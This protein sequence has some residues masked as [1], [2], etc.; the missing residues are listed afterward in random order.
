MM[1][2]SSTELTSQFL[3]NPLTQLVVV[4][5]ILTLVVLREQNIPEPT[6]DPAHGTLTHL[7]MNT[8]MLLLEAKAAIKIV[9]VVVTNAVSVSTQVMQTFSKRLVVTILDTGLQTKSV[10]CSKTM[11]LHSIVLINFPLQWTDSITGITTLVQDLV[12]A[13]KTEQELT[14]VGVP[15]GMS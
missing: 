14:A 9:T 1:L 2:R 10:V 3:W 11:E 8:I 7:Q 6:Q 4:I 15:T 13:I 5:M 12:V